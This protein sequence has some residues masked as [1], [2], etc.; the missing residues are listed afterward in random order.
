MGSNGNGACFAS[1]HFSRCIASY[2]LHLWQPKTTYTSVW[3]EDFDPAVQERNGTSLSV[4]PRQNQ[5][6]NDEIKSQITLLDPDGSLTEDMGN[7]ER[8]RWYV[9]SIFSSRLT[10]WRFGVRAALLQASGVFLIN[11]IILM[12]TVIKAEGGTVYEGDCNTVQDLTIGI[13]LVI[14]IL[15]TLLLGASN[16][17][18][19]SLCAPTRSEV[20]KAHERKSWLDIGLQSMRNLGYTSQW[21][22]FIWILL[23]A[24][25]IPLHLLWVFV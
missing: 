1:T 22:K 12:Y 8:S 17:V 3:T 21:K 16:Y 7:M 15:S 13:H 18:M 24:S 6:S 5:Q 23:S 19:Q 20:D 2:P 11:V 10:G 9:P 4:Y 25:S 14:N